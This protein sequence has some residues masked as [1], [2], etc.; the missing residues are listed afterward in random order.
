ML[1]GICCCWIAIVA[2]RTPI[3]WATN[4][5][6]SIGANYF[7]IPVVR[8]P[9]FSYGVMLGVMHRKFTPRPFPI[10]L[11]FCFV[12]IFVLLLASRS[13]WVAPAIAIL[14]GIAIFLIP[15]SLRQSNLRAI[16]TNRWMLLL[17]GSSYA[18][19]ILQLPV[20]L[21]VHWAL[22]GYS[23]TIATFVYLPIMIAISIVVYLAIEEPLRRSIRRINFVGSGR[24]GGT[25]PR[26]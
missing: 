25:E 26:T 23:K 11:N 17:G 24:L 5:L 9:E 3:F 22:D 2:F 19:Y 20:H 14:A 4:Q 15:N 12:A 10:L 7:I 16:L 21:I 13:T 18:L 6:D 8:L 1:I